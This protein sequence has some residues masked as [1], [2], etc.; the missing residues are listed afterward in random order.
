METKNYKTKIQQLIERDR[1]MLFKRYSKEVAYFEFYLVLNNLILILLN[2]ISYITKDNFFSIIEAYSIMI[3][4]IG[5]IGLAADMILNSQVKESS[6]QGLSYSIFSFMIF[7]SSPTKGMSVP[8]IILNLLGLGIATI[9][10]KL[11]KER[12][13]RIFLGIKYSFNMKKRTDI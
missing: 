12:Y 6:F 1:T 11:F 4:I 5:L 8:D 13:Y 9:L 2:I 10:L 7:I 3:N